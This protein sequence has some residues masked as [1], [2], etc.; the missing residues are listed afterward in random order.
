MRV[1][2]SEGIVSPSSIQAF[3]Y[4][5]QEDY[6]V[7]IIGVVAQDPTKTYSWTPGGATTS[8]VTVNPGATTTYTVSV[9]ETGNSCTNYGFVTVTVNPLP[10]TPTNNDDAQCGPGIPTCS[11][12]DPTGGIIRWYLTPTGG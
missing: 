6:A 3:T 8:S 1:I 10:A 2:I 12:T 11:V 7:D 9:N 5:E 4:G